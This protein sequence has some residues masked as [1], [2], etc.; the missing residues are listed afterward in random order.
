MGSKIRVGL[1]YGGKSGEHEVS[2]QTAFAVMGEFDYGKYEIKPFYITKKG[3]WKTGDVLHARPSSVRELQFESG[4]ATQTGL[5]LAPLFAGLN[6]GMTETEGE[7]RIDVVFPLL[8]GTFGEDGTIQGLF[9]MADIPYVGA[10]VLASAVGMDKILMKKVF[11]QEGLPQCVYRY[12]N[13]T[14]WEKDAAFFI[15]ECEVSLGYP[16][17]VKPANLGSSVGISKAKNREELIAAVNY[18]FRFDRKVIVEEFVDAREIEVSV[19][20]NDEA[21]ASVP[22][23]IAPSNEFYDYKAKYI[24][25]K[26]TMQIPAMLPADT[27]EAVREMAVRAFQAIDGSGLSRVD[28]FLRKSDNQLFINELNTMPGFTPFSMYPL[29]WKE[30][31]LSYKELLDTLINLAAARHADKQRIDFTGGSVE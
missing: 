1:V 28:F 4:E 19:L 10:G 16:C 27:T 23:E 7:R 24:D 13:R 5:A 17:F 12:F 9:E 11:A 26:S 3:Q 30:T 14:Q 15:M 25:G 22:G 31:G 29:M 21:K 8:H 6:G 20:G 2:L 18:A